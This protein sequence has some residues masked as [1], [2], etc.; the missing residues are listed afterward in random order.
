MEI[1]GKVAVVVGGAS[2]M[3]RA[4]AYELSLA[5]AKIAI[6]DLPS[7]EGAK[8]AEDIGQ[9][10]LFCPLDITDAEAVEAAT[11]AETPEA[12]AP[13]ED[14]TKKSDEAPAAGA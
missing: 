4:T 7:S 10:A 5:G 12:T 13:A 11:E 6:F 8:V 3:A 9:G 14:E 2:G 1:R